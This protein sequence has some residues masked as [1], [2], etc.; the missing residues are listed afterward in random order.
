M[1]DKNL[2]RVMIVDDHLMVRDGLKVFLSLYDDLEVVAD[3][4][5]GE[6]A[7]TYCAQLRPDVILMDVVMPGMDG[8]T[9]AKGLTERPVRSGSRLI[10]WSMP[11]YMPQTPPTPAMTAT[12]TWTALLASSSLRKS[13]AK[14][15]A[16]MSNGKTRAEAI[17]SSQTATPLSR[18][19]PAGDGSSGPFSNPC[20]VTGGLVINPP[21]RLCPV[22][23]RVVGGRHNVAPQYPG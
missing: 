15:K 5:D 16:I 4:G 10:A 19:W 21:V 11:Q 12:T 7:L 13:K 1:N 22:V 20:S 9:N 8:P 3:A 23:T 2:I 17:L 18:G 6:Q 14:K